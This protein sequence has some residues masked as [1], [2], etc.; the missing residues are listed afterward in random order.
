ML[1]SQLKP[2][3]QR[4][5]SHPRH[6]I[7]VSAVEGQFAQGKRGIHPH[8]NM[9]KAALNMLTRSIADDYAESGIYVNSVD[10]GWVSDQIPHTTDEERARMTAELPLDYIDAAARLYDPIFTERHGQ[11]PIFGKFLKDYRVAVW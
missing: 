11:T 10:P 7:N 1:I 4:G 2:L 9:A 5:D 6:I 3:M 8:T